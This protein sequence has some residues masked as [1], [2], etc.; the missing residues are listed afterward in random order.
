MPL[1]FDGKV[2]PTK[3]LDVDDEPAPKKVALPLEKPESADFVLSPFAGAAVIVALEVVLNAGEEPNTGLPPKGLGLVVRFPKAD[4]TG[5]V[6]DAVAPSKDCAEL[7]NADAG[8]GAAGAVACS[9]SVD[10]SAEEVGT[11]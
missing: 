10:I 3:T 5:C 7:S 6:E 8:G 9:F 11:T 2:V 4:F 1:E